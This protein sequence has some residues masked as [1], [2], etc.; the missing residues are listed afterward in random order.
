MATQVQ[1]RGGSTAE[2]ATFTGA[3]REI[4]VD[5]QKQTLV[6]HDG[7][8]VG[9]TP[10]QKQYPPLGS[11]AAPT[12]TFTGDTNTGIYSPGADQVAVATNGTGRLFVDAN[13]NVG[14]GL[15]GPSYPLEVAAP[16]DSTINITGGTSNVCRLF[17]SDTA[18]ARGFLNYAHADDSLHI[19]TA[20]TE[21]LRIT[22]AGRVGI[23]TSSPSVNLQVNAASDVG[24]A[25]SNSSSVTSGNRG[26]I[27]MYNSA[28]ST[29]G[30]IRFAAVT[31]NVGTEIQFY[32]RP[33]AGSLTQ[34]MTLDSTGRLGIGASPS[35]KLHIN[36]GTNENLWVGSLGGS[37]AGVYLAAVNDS[38]SANVPLNIGSASDIR[39]AIN[40]TEAA[41]ID[42]SGRLL[43]GTSSAR[44]DFFNG[45]TVA[46]AFQ[47]QG[48]GN[49]RIASIT[50][51]DTG[52]ASGASMI[53]AKSRSTG[54]TI[55]QSGDQLGQLSFQ[56]SDGVEIVEGAAINAIVDGT[57]GSNDLPTRLTFSTTADGASSPT[58]RMRIGSNGQ[59]QMGR[60]APVGNE[61]LAL[62]NSIGPCG[63]FFQGGNI[64]E[65]VLE[66]RNT[67]NQS[68]QTATYIR[69]SD[70]S[71]TTRGSIT[72]T[73]SATSY[74]TSS[75]Y[76]L[77]EN[78]TPVSDGISRL[79]QL[80]PNRF[81]FIVDPD[82]VVDGF[83]AHE[84]Q[85]IVPEAITGEKDAVDDDGNP[86][87]QGIDQSKLVPL[88]T[89]ALQEAIG[90]IETLQGMVAVNNITIDE[91]EHQISALAARLTALETP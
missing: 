19:G 44:S 29:V 68:G 32:T 59:I 36:T 90:E 82:T 14:V 5:T 30:N 50:A 74:N 48:E 24:I 7:S 46:P 39:F 57:P 84:V 2:H 10:L 63:Y 43:V 13:G 52:S 34:T 25:L 83:L 40:G 61:R 67:Y 79:K 33:A 66:L 58:E 37:G 87:Y 20:G 38:G 49:N 86:V 23:G 80:K 89:A 4:T 71:G 60:T 69:F 76:R 78:V 15:S 73:T 31:D 11:A 22:S 9:G 1:W 54:N 3:A 17:F 18:L 21:R 51:V 41:R 45:S 28:I 72:A 26:G 35:A 64:P 88:L 85:T 65:D 56:G 6:V 62:Q 81:N 75:D 91:Q 16:T 77:K 47:V 55:V 53:L 27:S 8:T 70:S 12:Y 42:S